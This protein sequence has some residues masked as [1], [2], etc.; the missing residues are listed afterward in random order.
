[1]RLPWAFPTARLLRARVIVLPMAIVVATSCSVGQGD[2]HVTGTLRVPECRSDVS[3]YDMQPDFFAASGAGN[4]LVI[5][6]QNGG[7]I[8][9]YADNLTISVQ[10]IEEVFNSKLGVPIRVG[11]DRRPSEPL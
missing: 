4:Q 2:G 9:E 6:I 10:D 3:N 5:P 8:Q 1:M 7:D 11:L